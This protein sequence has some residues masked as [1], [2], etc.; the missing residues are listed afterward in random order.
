MGEKKHALFA[1]IYCDLRYCSHC[2][3]RQFARLIEKHA[4]VLKHLSKCQR[5][6]YLLRQITLTSRNLKALTS[7]QVKKFNR[8]VKKALKRLMRGIEGWGA[9]WCDEVGFNN[10]NLHAHILFYGPYIAQTR[11]AAVW[12]EISDHEV[13]FISRAHRNGPKALV[14]LL[15]YVSKL[16]S[17]DPETVG[18]LEVAFHGRRRVHAVGLFYDFAGDDTDHVS[19]E[20]KLCPHCDSEVMRLPGFARIEKLIMEDRSFVG[21]RHREGKR[22]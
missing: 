2:G 19:S 4:P 20:W 1:P 13:V 6:G 3:P 15:K 10:Y 14:Y 17:N 21:A 22:K 8:D 7:E 9:I 5:P 18:H 11:L 16:P 12:R